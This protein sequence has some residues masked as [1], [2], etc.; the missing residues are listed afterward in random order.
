MEPTFSI[1]VPTYNRPAPLTACLQALAALE[2]P[3]DGYEVL[4]VDDG[5]TEPLGDVV[6]P[7]EEA[8]ALTLLRQPNAG[9]AEARNT[10]A[11]HARG[12]YLA[13][14][15]DDC[16][17]HPGWLRG[18][19]RQLLLTPGALLGGRVDN[20]LVGNA[21]SE[22]SQILLRYVYAYT[23]R[24]RTDRFRTSNNLALSAEGFRHIGGFDAAFGLAAGE[25][26]DFCN[27]WLRAGREMRSVPDAVVSH[28]HALTLHSFARQ[29]FQYGRGAYYY[30]Q[31]KAGRG[32]FGLRPD[33][34]FYAGLVR[35]PLTVTEG[36]RA[37]TLASLLFLSQVTNAAGFFYEAVSDR[38]DGQVP[39]F[40]PLETGAHS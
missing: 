18:F 28:A 7:F 30:H 26:R 32:G 10:G 38:I 4:V 19:E 24:T 17:P 31:F 20:A 21:F 35:Y 14:T 11:N 40:R 3:R 37:W 29:H 1:V 36:A 2:Y 15:D 9:P 13:F 12:R 27:R 6:R 33:L 22:A 34:S 5:S 39:G 8:M 23:E 25:D 16:A